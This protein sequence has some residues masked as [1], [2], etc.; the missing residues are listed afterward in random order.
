MHLGLERPP[1]TTRAQTMDV[2]SSQATIA[3]HAAAIEGARELDVLLPMLTT[4]GGSIR[5]AK[6]IALGV[7][8]AGLQAIATT[9]RL[10]AVVH[11][12]DVRWGSLLE[13]R[14]QISALFDTDTNHQ[15]NSFPNTARRLYP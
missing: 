7:G 8:V 13:G 15:H 1:R 2:L 5:P 6:M 4:A 11:G 12:F 14:S 10:G 9:R 3:G